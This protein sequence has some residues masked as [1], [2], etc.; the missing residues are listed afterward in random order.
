MRP[1]G[2]IQTQSERVFLRVTGA[3]DSERDIEAVNFVAGDRI[4]RLGDIATVRRG[5]VD[6]PQPAF[7]V[8]GKPAIGLAIAMRDAGDILA[9]GQNVRKDIAQFLSDL[10]LGIDVTLVADQSVAVDH[11]IGDF[12]TSLWQA[13]LIILACSFVSLGV[14][15]GAVVALAIP[16]TLAIV[17]AVMNVMHIDLHRISLGA[18]II[19]LTL[20]V[21]DAMTTVDAMIRRLGAGDSIDDAATF[22]YRTLAAPMLIGTLVTIASFVPIGFRQEQRRRVHVLDLLGGGDLAHRLV[23]RRRRVRAAG[24][25][26]AAQAAQRPAPT[27][28]R[29]SCSAPTRRSCAGRS[30]RA[31]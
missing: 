1:A 9:L 14:R 27:Q 21:D 31:G 23:A 25:Q 22:A 12:M 19:A 15:P 17:F 13:I 26:G 24:R 2:V 3:F 7:R 5:F 29:A 4:V 6:P 11:A 10:P 30:A 8:N 16:L 20:L 18:L 28:S